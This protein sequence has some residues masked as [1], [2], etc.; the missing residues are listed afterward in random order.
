MAEKKKER[1]SLG[2]LDA[3]KNKAAEVNPDA[4]SASAS[5]TQV[6]SNVKKLYPDPVAESMS[7]SNLLQNAIDETDD[8]QEAWSDD[9]TPNHGSDYEGNRIKNFKKDLGDNFDA[10]TQTSEDEKINI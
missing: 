4:A 2:F 6:E 7:K 9:E 10:Q 1:A 5:A 8:A 3:I